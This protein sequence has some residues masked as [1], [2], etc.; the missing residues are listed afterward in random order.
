MPNHIVK[1][2]EAELSVLE[3][4]IGQMGGLA[5]QLLGEAFEALEQRNPEQAN[6]AIGR[7]GAI[8]QLQ[9]ELEEQVIYFLNRPT[10]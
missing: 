10:V 8:D 7:D 5:E 6:A 3:T 1:S 4:K 9:K 2:Y